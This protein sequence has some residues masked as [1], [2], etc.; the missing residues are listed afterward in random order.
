ME[1]TMEPHDVLYIPRG[2]LHEASTGEDEPSLHITVTVPTSDYC[3]GVQLMKHLMTRVHHR[4]LPKSLHPLCGASLSAL[5]KGGSQSLRS[6]D[7]DAQIQELL[8]TWVSEL[9]VDGVL[10]TF[11]QRMARTNEGQERLF[12]RIMEQP[13]RPAVT[14]SCRVRLM[15]GISCWC[16]PDS[17]LAVFSREADNQQ[18]EMTITRPLSSLVRS[19]TSRPQWVTDLPCTDAFQRIC[20]LQLLHQQ[21]VVQ[22]FLV[23]PDEKTLP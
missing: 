11:E 13:M 8:S 7:L 17:D 19:L 15:H 5:G 2:Y 12:E 9:S 20:F 14:E 1:F 21:G 22:L 4:D 16:E 18:L 10:E 23:G 6:E 3:W